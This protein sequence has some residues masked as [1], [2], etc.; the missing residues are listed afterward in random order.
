MIE[1]AV[2]QHN[3]LV[4]LDLRSDPIVVIQLH[5]LVNNIAMRAGFF[6]HD[7]TIAP[8]EIICKT[9]FVP[10]QKL[11]SFH[12]KIGKGEEARKIY[13]AIVAGAKADKEPVS[14]WILKKCLIK[15]T[16]PAPP[17]KP[18]PPPIKPPTSTIPP[19]PYKSNYFVDENEEDLP[20]SHD[21][22]PYTLG[23]PKSYE[24]QNTDPNEDVTQQL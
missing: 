24:P 21:T 11:F 22:S 20:Q 4:Q 10:R 16:L 23:Q 18:T 8:F 2:I 19:P 14:F 6:S 5:D 1:L 12:V 17:P 9:Y 15:K 3:N 7:L 13:E